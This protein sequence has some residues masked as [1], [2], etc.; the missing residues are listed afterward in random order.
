LP[1]P[2]LLQLLP[3]RDPPMP[4]ALLVP[5]GEEPVT[6]AD[7]KSQLRVETND[8]DALLISFIAA[9]RAHVEALTRRRLVTQNWRV[10]LDVWPQRSRASPFGRVVELPLAPV[11]RVL[12]IRVYDELGVAQIVEPQQYRLDQ[13]HVPPRLIVDGVGRQP[14]RNGNG[15]EIDVVAGYGD[16][17]LVPAPLKQA[18]LR[19]AALWFEHRHDSDIANLA[20]TPPVVD[21]L[22][23]PYRVLW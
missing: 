21:A 7:L 22:I 10:Y 18:I 15:I 12:A 2:A 6:L 19:L 11:A 9:A 8:E 14:G 4:S 23:A 5:P 1:P 13:A 20:P 16:A 17:A 3:T